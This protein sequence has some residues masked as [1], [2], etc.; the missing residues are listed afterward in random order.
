L[1]GGTLY[2]IYTGGPFVPPYSTRDTH[3]I[4]GLRL[5]LAQAPIQVAHL[6][7]NLAVNLRLNPTD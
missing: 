7:L 6:G 4:F 5:A 1:L 2:T 3:F